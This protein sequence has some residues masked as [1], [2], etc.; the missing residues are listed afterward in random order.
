MNVILI[1]LH[2]YQFIALSF[3]NRHIVASLVLYHF[4]KVV[5]QNSFKIKYQIF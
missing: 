3:Y 1:I 5:S 4:L 2:F